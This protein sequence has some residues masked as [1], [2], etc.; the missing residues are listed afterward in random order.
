M[1]WREKQV[2]EA[3]RRRSDENIQA[4][5]AKYAKESGGISQEDFLN[6]C[7][8]VRYGLVSAEDADHI[9]R[10]MLLNEQDLLDLNEFRRIAKTYSPFE[11]FISKSIPWP[12]LVSS[13]LP[14]IV[15][16]SSFEVFR[17]LNSSEIPDITG[18]ICK[19]LE[20]ILEENVTQM[21][22]S[23][24]TAQPVQDSSSRFSVTELKAGNV[25]DYRQGLSGRIGEKLMVDGLHSSDT[26]GLGAPDLEFIT[27][28][29]D[30]HCT[31]SGNDFTFEKKN[32]LI[33]TPKRE[34]MI[35]TNKVPLMPDEAG[36]GRKVPSIDGLM[37]LPITA[38]AGLLRIEV[39]TMVLYTG[40]MVSSRICLS[41]VNKKS[42]WN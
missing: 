14:Q 35:A 4:V 20:K 34:W 38:K 39:I 16:K 21:R 18:A 11:Q 15:G 3:R 36:N 12:E 2:A 37:Q 28:V 1:S 6:A 13:A 31:K 25:E 7:Q 42:G 27:A 41:Y 17:E 33:T 22:F 10:G 8:E 29:E 9:F 32:G 19:E 24:K 26:T 5:Y 40:P 23:F 30:E